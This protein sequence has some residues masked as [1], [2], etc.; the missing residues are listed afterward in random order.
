M[1]IERSLE[2]AFTEYSA[3][4]KPP[5][6]HIIVAPTSAQSSLE[7][8][9]SGKSIRKARFTPGDLILNP[10]G[11]FTR[12][13]WDRNTR[14]TLVAIEPQLIEKIC[15]ELE[16]PEVAPPRK[17]HF[18]NGRLMRSIHSLITCFEKETNLMETQALKLTLIKQFIRECRPLNES[19]HQLCKTRL[20]IVRELV[21]DH[22][23]QP[24]TLEQMAQSAGYSAS[25]FL[26]LF[27][28]TTGLSPHQYL[29]QAR[30]K[31]ALADLSSSRT[32]II[33]IA[34]DCGFADQSHLTRMLKQCTGLTPWQ[35][36]KTSTP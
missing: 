35:F 9:E 20:A 15:T 31:K 18:Q 2:A 3:N 14:F 1:V 29:M 22:L 28:N 27:Q 11:S 32:P 21:H 4:Y 12:P 19:H 16:V 26:I 24:L 36:R 30:L 5:Q 17:F 23:A 25:R 10:E 33:Q 6:Q 8:L 13:R 7:W 34:T